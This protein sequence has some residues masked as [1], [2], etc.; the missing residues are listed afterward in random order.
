MYPYQPN[1]YTPTNK[2]PEKKV[3]KKEDALFKFDG[4][5]VNDGVKP[6]EEASNGRNTE[7]YSGVYM[8]PILLAGGVNKLKKNVQNNNPKNKK[9]EQ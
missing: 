3:D 6:K 4:D 1:K 8:P 9:D 2:A 7:R 5:I